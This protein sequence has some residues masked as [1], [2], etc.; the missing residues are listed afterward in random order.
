MD[1]IDCSS[2]GNSPE[3]KIPVGPL[4]Q[5]PFAEKLKKEAGI[6][7]AA[8][9]LITTA[10][11]GEKILKAQKADLIVMARQLLREPYFPLHAAKEL[12]LISHGRRNMK[13][14]N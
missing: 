9:G 7:T 8:V 6:L 14:L 5:V 13:E 10:K 3:Q 2:G 12:V 11:E 4:Y 1:V